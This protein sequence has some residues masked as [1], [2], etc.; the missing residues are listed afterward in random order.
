MIKDTRYI[1]KRVIIGVLICLILSFIRTCEVHALNA[2]QTVSLNYT[3]EITS[4]S[5]TVFNIFTSNNTLKNYGRGVLQFTLVTYSYSETTSHLNNTVRDVIVQSGQ[6]LYTCSIGNST[7][8]YDNGTD[9][10]VNLYSVLCDV[11]LGAN[12]LEKIDVHMVYNL[13]SKYTLKSSTYITF[14]SDL[15]ADNGAK[16]DVINSTLAT[17]LQSVYN[18]TSQTATN[19]TATN[20]YL[21]AIQSLLNTDLTA[22]I[23]ALT[24]STSQIV[25]S[26]QQTTT[27]VEDNTQ[28]VN[29]VND[30]LNDSS[31]DNPSNS[32]SNM[33]SQIGTN[34][35]ISDL[36]TLPIRFYQ[37][38]LNN[39]NSSCSPY[40]LGSLFNTN[41]TLPCIN[42]EDLLGSTIF[43]II[44][45]GLCGIFVW[46]IRKKFITIF[47]NITSLSDRGNEL[48]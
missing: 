9:Y 43:T 7:N 17:Y 39:V 44:D 32:F 48:E 1:I 3:R 25:T 27:A 46:S 42:I 6:N 34:T 47:Q 4:G 22:I 41:I 35:V 5:G 30:T 29:D 38:I 45:I 10:L 20:N 37:T 8:E 13:S 15:D 12:G 28:A 40:N 24:S 14:I 31:T 23:Q 33:N 11:N 36:L 16:L 2:I 19:T 21:S 26:Q 18:A